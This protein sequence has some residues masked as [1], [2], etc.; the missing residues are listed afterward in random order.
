MPPGTSIASALAAAATRLGARLDAEL[1][2]GHLLGMD[3]IGLLKE[4]EQILDPA[5][6]AALQALVVRRADGEPVA[7]LTGR[8]EFWSLEFIVDPRVL[9]PRPETELLVETA[10]ALAARAPAGT[11]VDVGT[12]SGA[13]AVALARELPARQVVALDDSTD[14][15]AVAAQNV[16]RL[17]PGRVDLRESDLLSACGNDS[18]AM[19]VSN[20]PY[21]EADWPELAA[22]LRHEPRH[23]LVAGR[24]GLD[25]IRRLVA[26]ARR[27]LHR[28]GWLVLEH[29]A[30]QGAAVRALLAEAGFVD[31]V[32]QRDL[33]GLERVSAARWP[34]TPT[35]RRA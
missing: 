18:F 35:V 9:V 16:A 25:V 2:L 19:V 4:R 6:E 11:V 32:T 26:D 13:V 14:A 10:L 15:L 33:A 34:A 30:R 24:D 22:N 20:P 29:G 28:D 31:L 3:R 23:A 1:L 5:V 21:V 12:G 7:Y 17:A 8:R 27:C